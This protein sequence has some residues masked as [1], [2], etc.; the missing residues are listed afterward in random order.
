MVSGGTERPVPGGRSAWTGKLGLGGGRGHRPQ[1]CPPA[2]QP[3][4]LAFLRCGPCAGHR[5]GPLHLCHLIPHP[6][7]DWPIVQAR[8]L[9]TEECGHGH[10]GVVGRVRIG[11]WPGLADLKS[12]VPAMD[13]DAYLAD[14]ERKAQ[15]GEA[16]AQG[17]TLS[18]L[19]LVRKVCVYGAFICQGFSRDDPLRQG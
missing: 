13:S 10:T 2:P 12:F 15:R 9:R 16:M 6:M 19:L 7:S 17:S 14:E 3:Q 1:G 4:G 18:H 8:T 5:L 11:T